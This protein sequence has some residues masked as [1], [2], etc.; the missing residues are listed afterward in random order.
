MY[1]SSSFYLVGNRHDSGQDEIWEFSDIDSPINIPSPSVVGERE[2]S[3]EM[4]SINE[5]YAKSATKI[6]KALNNNNLEEIRGLDKS[7]ILKKID[8]FF[9][10]EIGISKYHQNAKYLIVYNIIFRD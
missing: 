8:N 9:I 3:G 4:K 1:N 10:N 7:S 2:F 5:Y 6:I